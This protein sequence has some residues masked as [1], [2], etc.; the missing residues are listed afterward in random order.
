MGVT[1]VVGKNALGCASVRDAGFSWE[2]VLGMT[3]R[4]KSSGSRRRLNLSLN[5]QITEFKPYNTFTSLHVV[6][7]AVGGFF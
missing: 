7:V 3:S 2:W 6:V 5:Q 1:V 4:V